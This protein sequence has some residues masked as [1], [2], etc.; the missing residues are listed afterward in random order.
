MCLWGYGG[1]MVEKQVSKADCCF[2]ILLGL[3][4]IRDKS[5]ASSKWSY[6]VLL[7]LL[8]LLLFFFQLASKANHFAVVN[9][10][11]TTIASCDP[12]FAAA[13]APAGRS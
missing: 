8:L 3:K 7:L 9:S 5:V 10:S 6:V 12:A 4:W 13:P 11:E 1:A 2:D